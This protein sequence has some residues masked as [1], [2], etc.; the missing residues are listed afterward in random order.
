MGYY[1]FGFWQ[2]GTRNNGVRKFVGIS[3]GEKFVLCNLSW[4]AEEMELCRAW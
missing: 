4:R 1:I 3:V 2:V